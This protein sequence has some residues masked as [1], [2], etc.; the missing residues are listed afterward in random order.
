MSLDAEW[1]GQITEKVETH[2]DYHTSHFKNI[3]EMK[4]EIKA[5]SVKVT[6]FSFLGSIIGSGIITLI[7]AIILK[8]F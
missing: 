8:K 2:C 7:V 4:L 1:K 6:L 3:E 5:M